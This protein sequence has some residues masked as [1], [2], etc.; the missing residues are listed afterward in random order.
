MASAAKYSGEAVRNILAHNDRLIENPSNKD[1]DK[2]RT[3]LNYSLLDRGMPAYDYFWVRRQELHCHHRA[4]MKPLVGWVM[5]APKDLPLEQEAAFF[6][7]SY[8]F[9]SERYGEKNMVQATVHKDESGQAHLHV[10]FIPVVYDEKKCYEKICVN[11]VLTRRD[12]RTFHP[13]WQHYLQSCGIDASVHTGITKANGGNKTVLQ[14]KQER[15][16]QEVIVQQPQE[17]QPDRWAAPSI[18]IENPVTLH[19]RG[20][21]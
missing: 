11:D 12:L 14:M 5:T 15:E 1:I 6:E 9:V 16:I 7:A 13:D 4:D 2:S 17:M 19:E 18:D 10:C 3:P 8:R 21:W 20:R